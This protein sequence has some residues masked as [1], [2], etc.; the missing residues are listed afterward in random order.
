MDYSGIT[1]TQARRLL[2]LQARIEESNI[3]ASALD[4]SLNIAT[5]N[6][7]DFGRSARTE[8]G[9]LY[10][11][12]ILYQFDLIAVTEVRD[13]LSDLRRVLNRLGPYWKVIVSDWQGDRGGNR[14]RTAFVYDKRIVYFTG[15]AAEAQP[16]RRKINSEYLSDQSWWRAPYMASFRAGTFDFILMAA[17]IRW[18]TGAGRKKAL[19]SFGKWIKQR[20]QDNSDK[21]FDK[22]LILVGDFNIPRIGDAYYEAL[23]GPCGLIMP[24][25]LADV[26]DTVASSRKAR[27][28]QVLYLPTPGMPEPSQDG[29]VID[30]ARDGLMEE[31]LPD[32]SQS[33]RTW[34]LSDH[35]P[36]W[37]QLYTNNDRARLDTIIEG[38]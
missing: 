38:G 30:F 4:E 11:A 15:L 14:E 25:A 28:D 16:N 19:A 12:E 33:K 13:D 6:I 5:W 2:K 29:G 8:D 34:Q 21:V 24:P 35:F 37:M 31:L 22:D 17:H 26:H 18:G 7:R 20:W 32:I 1:P 3:P 23:C 27:Y 10:I 9:I 36:L